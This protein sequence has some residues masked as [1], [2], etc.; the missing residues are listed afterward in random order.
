MKK[1][2]AAILLRLFCILCFAGYVMPVQAADDTYEEDTILKE[3][4]AFF[5]G[6]AEGLAE[7]IEKLFKEQGRPNAFIKGQEASGAIVIGARYGDGTLVKKGGGS[8]K[9]HWTGPSI[10]FDAGAPVGA[11]GFW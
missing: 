11:G 4:D 1:T 10:G 9:V 8:T 2:F 5:G 7:V 3:A 6:G